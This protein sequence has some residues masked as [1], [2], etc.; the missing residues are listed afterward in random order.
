MP[1]RRV[2]ALTVAVAA[3]AVATLLAHLSATRSDPAHQGTV[4][5]S[6]ASV[7]VWFNQ[8]PVLAVSALTLE[9]PKGAVKLGQV[10]AGANRSLMA[11]V[12]EALQP[13]SHTLTWRT[14]GNDGHVISGTRTFTYAPAR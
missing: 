12:L 11:E 5:E 6:P 3:L 13:G 4:T 14:A 2:T 7:T 10:K 8:T 1:A 9:G